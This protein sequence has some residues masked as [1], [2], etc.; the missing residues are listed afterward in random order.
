MSAQRHP[1]S[2][3]FVPLYLAGDRTTRFTP[4]PAVDNPRLVSEVNPHGTTYI[5]ALLREVASGAVLPEIAEARAGY[6]SNGTRVGARAWASGRAREPRG[7][8]MHCGRQVPES[9][10]Y[11]RACNDWHRTQAL[12]ALGRMAFGAAS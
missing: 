9:S 2:Q 10:R 6:A 7:T 4:P 1:I 11:A 12:R 8:C 3:R 5:K